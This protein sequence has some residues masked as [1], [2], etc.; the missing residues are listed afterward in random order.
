MS[1]YLDL[2]P[3]LSTVTF[4]FRTAYL[5]HGQLFKAVFF[6]CSL[7]M[8][9]LFKVYFPNFKITAKISFS[10]ASF[11]SMAYLYLRNVML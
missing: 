10:E 4:I 5:V 6:N 11:K 2:C 9:V 8:T 3:F 7:T 1:S